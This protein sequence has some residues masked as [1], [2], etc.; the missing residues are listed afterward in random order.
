M[1]FRALHIQNY[2]YLMILKPPSPQVGGARFYKYF[3]KLNKV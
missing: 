3:F 2:L 1:T